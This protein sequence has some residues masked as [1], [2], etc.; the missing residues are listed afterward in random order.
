M[1]KPDVL[2]IILH[3]FCVLDSSS[4]TSNDP[5]KL[6]TRL[7]TECVL[8]VFHLPLP[9]KEINSDLQA[10]SDPSHTH[11]TSPQ[12]SSTESFRVLRRVQLHSHQLGS[13]RHPLL[14]LSADH[15]CMLP[16]HAAGMSR[17]LRAS[18]K[19][20]FQKGNVT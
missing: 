1:N 2:V 10:V 6:P 20:K 15:K 12:R 7:S 17:P 3:H 14:R 16:I 13:T 11:S 18:G 4:I 5:N 9:Y 8:R 19:N